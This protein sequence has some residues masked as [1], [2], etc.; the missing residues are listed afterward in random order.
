MT[1]INQVYVAIGEETTRGTAENSTVGFLPVTSGVEPTPNPDDRRRGEFRG[2]ESSLGDISYRRMSRAWNYELVFNA[3]SEAGSTKGIVGTI[4]R[5]FFGFGSSAQNGATG[6]YYH[7]MYPV[8]NPLS[9]DAGFLGAKA[10]TVNHNSS[11]GD[12]VKNFPWA[13]GICQSLKFTQQPSELL[14]ISIGM[15][16]QALPT[17]E[18]EI[19]SPTFPAENLRFDY[20]DL[21]CYT[22][23]I[24]RTGTG[25]DYTNFTFG[26]ATSF[27]PTSY[28]LTIENGKTDN[29]VLAGVDY[30]TVIKNGKFKVTL[31]MVIDYSDPAAGFNPVDQWANSLAGIAQTN[32]FFHYDTGTQAGT[33]DNH[34]LYIDLPVLNNMSK[35]PPERSLEE[36]PVITLNYEGD[37][38]AAT[39]A[40]IIGVMLKNTA[41]AI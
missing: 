15:V 40:Y 1:T 31:S 8:Y 30:P 29:I 39:T 16:G 36:D 10:L 41:T 24:T 17:A 25:P 14:S 23:T 20:A 6:Q 12:T 37:F 2:E 18:A 9:T 33:G 27:I 4:L 34:Q 11:Q 13:G 38:D 28:E 3:F 32:F 21:T 35:T 7:M 19:G 22:G 5:H 26:S